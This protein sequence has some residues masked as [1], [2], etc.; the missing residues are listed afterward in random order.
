MLRADNFKLLSFKILGYEHQTQHRGE[1]GQWPK[2][3]Q[4]PHGY[5]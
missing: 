2:T 5:R 3:D 1:D 4:E